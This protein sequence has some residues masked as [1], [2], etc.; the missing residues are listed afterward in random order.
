M[1]VIEMAQ[2]GRDELDML[3]K[4]LEYTKEGKYAP[5]EQSSLSYIRIKEETDFIELNDDEYYYSVS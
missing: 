3:I 2:E 4:F 1:G 5:I